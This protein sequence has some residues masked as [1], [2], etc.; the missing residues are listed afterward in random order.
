[1]LAR[2]LY[3]YSIPVIW[4]CYCMKFSTVIIWSWPHIV[5]NCLLTFRMIRLYQSSG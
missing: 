2:L 3:T 5:P 1:M 4:A